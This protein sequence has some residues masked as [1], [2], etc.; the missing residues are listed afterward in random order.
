MRAIRGRSAQNSG[1]CEKRRR[2]GEDGAEDGR[3][4]V[5]D[6]VLPVLADAGGVRHDVGDVVLLVDAVQQVS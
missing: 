6:A 3:P 1:D 2:A 5:W 4:A